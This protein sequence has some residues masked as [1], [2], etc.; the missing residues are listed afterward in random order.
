MSETEREVTHAL[1]QLAILEAIAARGATGADVFD[2]VNYFGKTYPEALGSMRERLMSESRRQ[3]L[4]RIE[5]RGRETRWFLTE[6]GQQALDG[7]GVA[8][9]VTIQQPSG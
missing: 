9:G 7:G 1:R 6:M 2:I 5:R 4:T 3:G 8:L